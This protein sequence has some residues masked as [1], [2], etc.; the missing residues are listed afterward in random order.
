[1]LSDA[2]QVFCIYDR[3]QDSARN[4]VQVISLQ[5]STTIASGKAANLFLISG[6]KLATRVIDYLLYTTLTL[7]AAQSEALT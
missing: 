2:T 6:N 5:W 3:R 7:S 1:M 4:L